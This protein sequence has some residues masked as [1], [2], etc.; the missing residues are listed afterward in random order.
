MIINTMI[1][2]AIG[3]SHFH[4]RRPLTLLQVIKQTNN[5]K[6]DAESYLKN[7]CAELEQQGIAANYMVPVGSPAD[8]IINLADELAVDLVAMSTR[9]GTNISFWTIGSVA[10]KVLLAGSTPLLLVRYE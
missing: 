9:G 4:F 6:A 8:E 1:T 2:N 7:R 5:H 3:T 10:Q